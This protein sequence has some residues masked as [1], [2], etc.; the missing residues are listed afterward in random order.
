MNRLLVGICTI[1]QYVRKNTFIFFQCFFRKI[2]AVWRLIGTF[3]AYPCEL[4]QRCTT[5]TLFG[6]NHHFLD[7]NK[8]ISWSI[9][10]DV[11]SWLEIIIIGQY[12][13]FINV[14]FYNLPLW[15][16]ISFILL[17]FFQKNRH[18]PNWV[19]ITKLSVNYLFWILVLGCLCFVI[20]LPYFERIVWV[21]YLIDIQCIYLINW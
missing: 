18:E 13:T 6:I 11:W 17:K 12:L 4:I 1:F 5:F 16:T 7:L 19:K 8:T 14:S 10:K 9:Y 2:T 21:F 15:N 3:E 20:Y